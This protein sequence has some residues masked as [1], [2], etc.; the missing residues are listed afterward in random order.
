MIRISNHT[1]ARGSLSQLYCSLG[2]DVIQAQPS[3]GLSLGIILGRQGS[4]VEWGLL[5]TR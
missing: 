2:L 3:D 5:T 4:H 1:E